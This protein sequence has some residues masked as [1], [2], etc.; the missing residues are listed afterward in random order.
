[1]QRPARPAEL[2]AALGN[3]GESIEGFAYCLSRTLLTVFIDSELRA[4]M[5]ER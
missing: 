2:D 3:P 5:L 4:V 1:V